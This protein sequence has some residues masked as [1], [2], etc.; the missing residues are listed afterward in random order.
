MNQTNIN[1][2]V[3]NFKKS[4]DNILYMIIFTSI[5]L[6]LTIA[7]AGVYLLFSATAPLFSLTLG[8]ALNESLSSN[9][10]VIIGL[11]IALIMVAI[12]LA[13]W[14]YANRKRGLILVAFI[15][16]IIDTLLLTFLVFVEGFDQ[17]YILDIVF[18]VWILYYLYIGTMAWAKL[19]KT[20]N[21]EFNTILNKLTVTEA[22]LLSQ[23]D[24]PAAPAKT[25]KSKKDNSKSEN[26]KTL[27]L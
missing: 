15:F 8:Q 27:I 3:L 21:D 14:H 12:Y 26:K 18:H 13:C 4:R 22:K 7:N 16:F 2:L 6:V 23:I 9:I 1:Q 5:N 20:N 25:K 11:I 19:R 10:Y 24:E 17:S